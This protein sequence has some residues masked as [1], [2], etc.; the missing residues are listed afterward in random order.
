MSTVMN[1]PSAHDPHAKQQS[2]AELIAEA[3]L[4][5]TEADSRIEM[6]TD[7]LKKSL[8]A[9]TGKLIV[10]GV[11]AAAVVGVLVW[12]PWQNKY[13]RR[14]ARRKER[15]LERHRD[16]IPVRFGLR[17]S[18]WSIFSLIGLLWPLLPWKVPS[19]V[20]PKMTAF[21]MGIGL[22]VKA[23]AEDVAAVPPPMVEDSFEPVRYFG[24]WYEIARLPLKFESTCAGDVT[25]TYAPQSDGTGQI[26]VTNR[27]RSVD[28][29]YE[30]AHGIAKLADSGTPAKLKV[31]FAPSFMRA[32]PF[33][34]A[35][36]WILQVDADYSIAVVGTPDRNHLWLLAREPKVDDATFGQMRQHAIDQG[37]DLSTL[38]KT[39]HTS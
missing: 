26:S 37:Y 30:V 10:G 4:A 3:E 35:D 14:L 12:R 2:T 19:P 7:T 5:I 6:R 33:V 36:Y 25:A 17:D 38:I 24:R 22:P 31:T 29:G 34:W 9:Q 23:R 18:R 8:V 27:C 20:G 13:K 11:V 39:M 16:D 32:L 21:L 1:A 15:F 28:G